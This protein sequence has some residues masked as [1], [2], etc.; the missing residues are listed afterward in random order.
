MISKLWKRRYDYL[1]DL[2]IVEGP[3]A[4]GH[5][6]FTKEELTSRPLPSLTKIIKDVM[7]NLKPF[8]EENGKRIPVVAGGGIFDSADVKEVLDLGVQGIQVG[9]RFVATHECDASEEFKRAYL[10][11]KEEDID[12]ILSPVGMPG[13]AIINPFIKRIKGEKEKITKCYKCLLPCKPASTPYCISKALI[14]SVNGDVDNGLI[15]IGKRIYKKNNK[16]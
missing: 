12:Y 11:A 15:F 10:N 4:G 9:T 14:N 6:G 5:L 7:E 13:Q 8:E 3:K 1:P 16:R 2:V